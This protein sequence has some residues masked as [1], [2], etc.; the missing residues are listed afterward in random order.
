MTASLTPKP[1]KQDHTPETSNQLLKPITDLSFDP[2]AHTYTFRGKRVPVSVTSVIS[3]NLNEQARQKIAATKHIWQPRGEDV[4]DYGEHGLN[5]GWKDPEGPY[6]EWQGALRDFPLWDRYSAIATEYRLVDRIGGRYAGSLDALLAGKDR[7][8][9]PA[10]LL[11][12]FKTKS[13][14]GTCGD[15]RAQLGAYTRMLNQWHATTEITRC[16]VLNVFPGR[17]ELSVYPVSECVEAWDQK[18][19]DYCLWQPAF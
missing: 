18:W 13:A 4:H 17:V 3:F 2:D 12:D 9:T 1:S 8:G 6:A 19:K 15:H 5:H 14:N 10:V 16:L 11:C 7:D